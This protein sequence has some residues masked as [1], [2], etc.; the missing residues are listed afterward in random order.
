MFLLSSAMAVVRSSIVISR[1]AALRSK[2]SFLKLA[3]C[4]S[5]SFWFISA[6]QWSFLVSSSTCCSLSSATMS[7]IAFLTLVKLSSFTDTARDSNAVP[8]DLEKACCRTD[9]ALDRRARIIRLDSETSTNPP[10]LLLNR[11]R[12]SSEVKMPMV[13]AMALSSS[14]RSEERALYSLSAVAQSLVTSAKNWASASR[15][16]VVSS[17]SWVAWSLWTLVSANVLVLSSICW[18]SAAIS[19]SLAALS[20]S[21]AFC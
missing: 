2:S 15:V 21:K 16:V 7:S 13:A 3:A 4:L 11:A 17:R 19:S 8:W 1:S 5:L 9:E 6:P 12:A 10:M 20:S 14:L 18:V